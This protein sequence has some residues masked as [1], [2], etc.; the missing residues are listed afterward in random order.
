[1]V[2]RSFQV[3]SEQCSSSHAPHHLCLLLPTSLSR[4]TIGSLSI[5]ICQHSPNTLT[6]IRLSAHSLGHSVCQMDHSNCLGPATSQPLRFHYSPFF[7]SGPV[8][9]LLLTILPVSAL[10]RL[11]N[12]SMDDWGHRRLLSCLGLL[13]RRYVRSISPL[14]G[15]V[16]EPSVSVYD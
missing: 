12:S 16:C 3:T 14:T 11:S 10:R 2:Q 5:P 8:E 1:V 13:L 7:W 6:N 9:G 4:V 15:R